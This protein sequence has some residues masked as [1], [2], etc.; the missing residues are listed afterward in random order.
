MNEIKT[1]KGGKWFWTW[2]PTDELWNGGFKSIIDAINDAIKEMNEL[3]C[4]TRS[5]YVAHGRKLPKA[6]C[7]EW[8]INYP[9]YAVTQETA[10]QVILPTN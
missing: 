1:H 10:L 7:E 5:I 2:N 3:E 4:E 9:F 8:G 6:E